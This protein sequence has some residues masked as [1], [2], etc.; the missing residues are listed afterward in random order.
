MLKDHKLLAEKKDAAG[1]TL[2]AAQQEMSINA[3]DVQC[4]LSGLFLHF[5][6]SKKKVLYP[7]E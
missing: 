5:T 3:A 4:Q 6:A 7:A 1:R 2:E